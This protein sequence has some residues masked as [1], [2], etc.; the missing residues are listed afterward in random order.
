MF[1][2]LLLFTFSSVTSAYFVFR[3]QQ[4]DHVET[5]YRFV[6]GFP[7]VTIE[8]LPTGVKRRVRL[9]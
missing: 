7:W 6:L 9:F 4:N 2:R 5:N 8:H 1:K 3:D